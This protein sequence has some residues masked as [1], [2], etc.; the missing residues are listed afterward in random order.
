MID[1]ILLDL[2]G[3]LLKYTQATFIS[4][5]FAELPKVFTRMG[6]DAEL[7]VK[8][9]W[10][11]TKAMILND[12]GR[13]NSQRFWETFALSLA[14]S[15]EDLR[16]IEAACDSFYEN[17]FNTVKTVME[18]SEIPKRLVR[19]LGSKGY[20]VVLATNPLFPACAVATRLGWIGLE[21]RDFQLITHYANSMYCKP[22]LGYYR[23]IFTKIGK[24]PEQC[25]M[26]GNNPAEDMVVGTLGCETFLVTDCLENESGMD[27]TTLRRGT[28]AELEAY[29]ISLPNIYSRAKKTAISAP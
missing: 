9:V 13:F 15:D 11:G 1:T 12:G 21:P 25:L 18:P 2:D 29:L 10:A 27:I 22:D 16:M 6:M 28:L 4:V 23:E 8:A 26:A 14:L 20:H 7:T 19:A 24:M 3:T 17:E 5:Y